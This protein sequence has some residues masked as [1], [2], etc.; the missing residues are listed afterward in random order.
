M[1]SIHGLW[2]ESWTCC[3]RAWAEEGCTRGPHKGQPEK[4]LT[5]LCL[6]RG[7]INPKTKKPDSVC[8][9]EFKDPDDGTCAFHPGY[10]KSID[11]NLENGVWTCCGGLGIRADP[12]EKKIHVSA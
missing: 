4:K 5:F 8:G 10:L 12:C 11:N 9:R 6:Q 1:G 7:Q 3:R 2:P